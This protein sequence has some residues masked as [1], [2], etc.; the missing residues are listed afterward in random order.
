MNEP[1]IVNLWICAVCGRQLTEDA[2]FNPP[3]FT[4]VQTGTTP[5]RKRIMAPALNQP[6]RM[7]PETCAI[8]WC[9]ED[10]EAA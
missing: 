9:A 1:E 8:C 6:L 3:T 7:D 10:A 2:L 4:N 5:D